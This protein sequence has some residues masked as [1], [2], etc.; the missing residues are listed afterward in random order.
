M[1]IELKTADQLEYGKKYEIMP[2]YTHDLTLPFKSIMHNNNI[3]QVLFE[4]NGEQE[5][6]LLHLE[7]NKRPLFKEIKNE[8]GGAK[9]KSSRKSHK[10]KTRRNRRKSV[11]RNRRH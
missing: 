1:N 11:R 4:R 5:N 7:D 8:G 9:L 6:I 10:K 2:S 3:L